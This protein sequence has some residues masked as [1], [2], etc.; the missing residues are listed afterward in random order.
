MTRAL[1][2]IRQLVEAH[3][4]ADL[5][6]RQLL[7]RFAGRND[8]AA[9]AQL[10]RRHG[11]MVLGVCRRVLGNRHDAEDAFQAAFLVL[12]RR[13]AAVRWQDSAGGWL[14]RVA[15]HLAL[16]MRAAADRRRTRPLPDVAGPDAEA[17]QPGW[18]LR[19]ILDEELGRLP[20]KYRA[21]LLLCHCEGK[22]RAEAARRLGWKEG[23][24][25]IRLE[26]GRA[27]LRARLARRGLAVSGL[28]LGSLL[29]PG[30]ATATLP[31]TLVPVVVASARLFALGKL[32]AAAATH[33]AALAE[34]VLSAMKMTRLKIAALL[35]LAVGVGALGMGLWARTAFARAPGETTPPRQEAAPQ[36]PPG[37][38]PAPAAAPA[39]SPEKPLRVLLFAG[40]PTRDYQFVRRLFATQADKKQ[41][42]LAI[43]LQPPPGQDR[44]R[45]GIVQD[46]PPERMLKQ[47]P[48]R[49]VAD[50][51]PDAE[52]RY[53]NLA[54][55]DVIIAFDPDWVRLTEEQGQL[56]EKWVGEKGHGLIVV[57]GPIN[58]LAL[59]RPNNARKLKP[60]LD[61]LPVHLADFR[62]SPERDISRPWPLAFPN[63]E[64]FLKL[65]EDGKEPLAG[66]SEFF[67][68]KQR[69]DWQKTD[70]RPLRGFYT[71]YP[72]KSVKPAATVHATFRDPQARIAAGGDKT[73]DLPYLVAMPYGKGR[74]VYL[75]SGETWRLR[76][77]HEGW[78]ERFWN[79]LAR[80][81]ASAGAPARTPAPRAPAI[82]P[83][84]RKATDKALAWLAKQ[85]YRD[86]HWEG[87]GGKAPMVMTSLGGLALLM[88]GTT[89]GEGEYEPNLRRAVDWVVARSQRDGLIGNPKNRAEAENYMDGHG[90]ALLLLASVYGE[91]E[92]AERRRKLHDVL[93]RAVEFTVKAQ[94]PGGGWGHLSRGLDMEDDNQAD[95]AATVLQLQGLRAARGAG[96]AVPKKALDSARAYLE[97]T[98]EP[99]TPAATV[100]LVGTFAAGEYD[101]P[102]VKK[103]L[104]SATKSAPVLNPNAKA[105]ADDLQLYALALVAYVLGDEGCAKLLPDSKPDERITWGG[106]RKA[107]FDYLIKTQKTDGS[108]GDEAGE[109]QATALFLAVLQL[110]YAVLPI[111]QK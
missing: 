44:P 1:K 102:A 31:A 33:S 34:G 98:I 72:V 12:A 45:P 81:A 25:K 43:Y 107:A 86:G 24:V 94:T 67:F 60:I 69:D 62:L 106:F 11:P 109:V 59:A 104:R 9:F 111:Y 105:P 92:D 48:T 10:V 6:D 103:W 26:R 36:Q 19:A 3:D 4:G 29:A 78:H 77:F 65:D 99:A 70:D 28:L 108:W 83:E 57:A 14:F 61:V 39:P 18:E 90:R 17:G 38:Q 47:F 89:I 93:T 5:S 49:L 73:Q 35:L 97:K 51:K 75:G 71:A 88:Q 64:K 50:E 30:A 41:A 66:W 54:A 58:S 101:T 110:D 63:A 32:S 7:E 85:Q 15:Y 40:A 22:T 21:V 27:L 80:Y 23:A 76:Q 84:Q 42:E 46:V 87:T 68:G 96:I 100:G 53:G 52:D 16:K 95:V 2:D 56:L 55:Y 91:E 8:E 20:E 82:T 37:R 74:T 79:Q 13:A